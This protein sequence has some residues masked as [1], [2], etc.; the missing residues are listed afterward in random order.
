[1]RS[2]STACTPES[3]PSQAL[4]DPDTRA[5]EI[6]AALEEIERHL[7]EREVI[8]YTSRG[9]ARAE[10]SDEALDVGRSVS[11]AL[12]EL[13]QRLDPELPLAFCVAKGGITSS[14]IGSRGFGVRRAEVA[15]QMLPGTI[16]VWILPEESAFP[17]LPYV[18]F[19]GQ[20]R[21]G[22]DTGRGHPEA[23]HM[24]RFASVLAKASAEGRAVGAFTCYDLIGFEAVVRAA[25]ANTAPVIVLVG[26]GSFADEGGERLVAAFR[27]AA[28]Q[29][30]VPVLVQLDHAADRELISRAAA[31]G[32]DGDADGSRLPFEQNL[33]FSTAVTEEMRPLGVAVEAEL[34]RVE[35]NEDLAAQASHG[36]LTDP[37]EAAAFVRSS[38]ASCL[39]VSIGNV[40]GHYA[41]MPAL[42]WERL[43]ALRGAGAPLALHGASG[44]P[45]ADVR[46]AVS[47][48]I[49]KVNVNTE[50]RAAY[51]G[52]LDDVGAHAEALDLRGLGANVIAAVAEAVGT[53]LAVLGWGRS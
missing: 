48:G 32:V 25:A 23:R 33:A 31:I 53:K 37:A 50:L 44:L 20:R 34:G 4:L 46:R 26:P 17:G 5:Q 30:P 49:A 41:G 28:A 27:A 8:V 36:A 16:S 42:D 11:D 14:D 6:A 1:M 24:M 52:A 43:E 13:V 51:F 29:A 19:P 10:G 35:G 21:R 12:V 7:P 2:S 18:I 3:C 39:A 40:H 45:D 38:G 15:G 22:R 47:L 9:L